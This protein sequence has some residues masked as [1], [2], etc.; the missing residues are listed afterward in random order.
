MFFSD[1]AVRA[2]SDH[3]ESVSAHPMI[4]NCKNPVRSQS[5]NF[6]RRRKVSA[7]SCDRPFQRLRGRPRRLMIVHRPDNIPN[8]GNRLYYSRHT[9]PHAKSIGN[10]RLLSD[11][12]PNPPKDQS[13]LWGHVP[14]ITISG[15]SSVLKHVQDATIS[16]QA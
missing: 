10:R 2:A 9:N 11:V 13:A 15:V 8:L 12:Q 16:K 6:T 3:K 5:V 14:S 7:N 4:S 1:R